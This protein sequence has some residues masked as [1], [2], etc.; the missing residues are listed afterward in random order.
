MACMQKVAAPLCV[1]IHIRFDTGQHLA[2]VA[3]F[4]PKDSPATG[5]PLVNDCHISAGRTEMWIHSAS[6][7]GGFFL[8]NL[9][10]QAKYYLHVP[11]HV[12]SRYGTVGSECAGITCSYV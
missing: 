10:S 11:W 2:K 4:L 8:R 5:R 9:A 12:H 7:K 1:Q 6:Q 3:H